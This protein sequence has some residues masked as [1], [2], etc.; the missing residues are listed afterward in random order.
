[1]R[2]F[3]QF[4]MVSRQL[5]SSILVQVCRPHRHITVPINGSNVT[6]HAEFI[7]ER[8]VGLLH[9]MFHLSSYSLLW[10]VTQHVFTSARPFYMF[11]QHIKKHPGSGGGTGS[12]KQKWFVTLKSSFTL[13][14]K[15]DV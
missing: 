11:T 14:E 1:M 13:Y 8:N 3:K 4:P 6:A 5:C 2:T 15:E 10:S 9:K 12:A 7:S